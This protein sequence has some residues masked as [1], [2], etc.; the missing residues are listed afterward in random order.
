MTYVDPLQLPH[1]RIPEVEEI[2]Q[3]RFYHLSEVQTWAVDQ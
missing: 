1:L 3:Q 2:T